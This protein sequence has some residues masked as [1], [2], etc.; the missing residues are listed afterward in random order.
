MTHLPGCKL[1][2]PI[3]F[4]RSA[5]REKMVLARTDRVLLLPS[6][7]LALFDVQASFNLAAAP[8]FLARFEPL[9]G[10]TNEIFFEL[11]VSLLHAMVKTSPN[12]GC[13]RLHPHAEDS[14]SVRKRFHS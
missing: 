11:T 3:P 6:T 5:L 2:R 10:E 4:S 12:L 13:L 14:Q 1:P 8:I 9:Q 7:A